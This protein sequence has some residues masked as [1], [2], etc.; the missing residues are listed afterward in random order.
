MRKL[1]AIILIAALFCG[2]LS[3]CSSDVENNESGLTVVSTVF[4]PYDFARELVGD[5][6][7]V[8]L[9]LPPGSES[10]S[11]EPSPKDIIEIQNCD[12]FIYVGGENDSWVADV[13]ESVGDGVR[14]VTLM[15]CVE[16]LEEELVEGMQSDE[17]DHDDDE[18]EYDEHVWTSP[19]NAELIAAKICAAL[20]E[21]AP[22]DADYFNNNLATYSDKLS[23]LDAAFIDAVAN[24][25]RSTII[26]ADRFPLAYFAKA[27]GLNYFAAYPGCSDDAEPSAATVTFLIDKVIDED[28]PVVFHI[29]LSNE[30]LAD[31]VCEETGAKKLLFS[32]CHNVT[33]EQFD[34][35]VSYLDLMWANVDTLKEALG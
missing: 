5:K 20:C 13:L 19:R 14:C 27:Y 35:G 11:Y 9:L 10:H 4:A 8:S 30:E 3:A 32:A 34:T 23:E 12:V 21:A 33:R 16:L 26:F 17:H 24:G 28:I 22:E 1:F 25:T 31:T 18:V 6:G 2:L 7:S 29:E 15:D